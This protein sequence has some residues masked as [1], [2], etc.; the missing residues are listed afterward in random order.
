MADLFVYSELVFPIFIVMNASRGVKRKRSSAKLL[1]VKV[2]VSTETPDLTQGYSSLGKSTSLNKFFPENSC[3][4]IFVRKRACLTFQRKHHSL[5]E[6]KRLAKHAKSNET[7]IIVKKLKSLR[8]SPDKPR[9]AKTDPTKTLQ[10]LEA[11]LAALKVRFVRLEENPVFSP[12]VGSE[13]SS[14]RRCYPDP[15]TR[16]QPHSICRQDSV[17]IHLHG[18]PAPSSPHLLFRPA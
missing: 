11:Q 12:T 2:S 10:D 17:G 3:A 8:S 14:L 13:S 6:F 7:R 9:S 16:A 18:A 1:Q 15:E 5:Q 4:E